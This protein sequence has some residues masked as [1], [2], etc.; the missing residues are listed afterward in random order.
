MKRGI[1]M[2][3]TRITELF[4]VKYPIVLAGMGPFST[5]RTAV[6]V[7][8]AG[9]IGLTSHWAIMTEVDPKTFLISDAPN[10]ITVSPAEKIDYDLHYIKENAISGAVCGC[11]IRV[12][13]VQA[14]WTSVLRR[15]L[16]LCREDRGI[17]EKIRIIVTSAGDPVPPHKKIQ[18]YNEKNHDN[19]LH[20][21]VS[22][23]LRLVQKSF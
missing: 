17:R 15:V 2:I 20:F 14:D 19:L 7:A 16:K 11:N 9:G 13:R 5:Y 12:A 21:H 10:A 3:K 23:C 22:P 18:K 6:K 1:Y 4:D 8:N